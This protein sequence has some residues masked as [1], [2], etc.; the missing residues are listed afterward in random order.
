[1][2]VIGMNSTLSG[3]DV[4]AGLTST[5]AEPL[6]L[7][8]GRVSV[9]NTLTALTS[10]SYWEVQNVEFT[11]GNNLKA[12]NDSRHIGTDSLDILPPGILNVGLK[13]SLRFD[14]STMYDYMVNSTKL[15]AEFEFLGDTLP[16]SVIREGIKVVM[17]RVYV[18]SGGDPEV[19]SPDEIMKSEVEFDV[20]G[21][22]SSSGG[23][24]VKCY[25]TN[26]TSS[27]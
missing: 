25:V 16:G 24:A 23:Y 27:Y 15:S 7:V 1:M 10:T 19:G 3:N 11:L 4:Q 8:S 17:P 22:D 20:V 26:L 5:A 13:C 9:E 6:S 18:K 12:D 21:D 2:S 14:T